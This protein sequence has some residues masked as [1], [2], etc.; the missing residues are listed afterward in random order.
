[1]TAMS[2]FVPR[3]DH[4]RRFVQERRVQLGD[5]GPDGILRLD[6]LVR[7]LQDV[8][9]EDWIDSGLS[10]EGTWVVRRTMLRIAGSGRWPSLYED[11]ALVTWCGGTGAAWAERRT[12]V[13]I[14][15][16]VL[17][18][19]V[20]LWVPVDARGRPMRIDRSFHDLYG[21]A[22][23]GRRVSGRVPAAPTPASPEV[24]AWPIRRADLDVVGH[25]NNAAIWA[26]LV[27]VSG[28]TVSR[29][30]LTHHG[31]VEDGHVVSLLSE[32]GRMWLTTDDMIRVSAEYCVASTP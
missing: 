15:G 3:P 4:G 11:V 25:V 13:E 28:A 1:M 17:L 18:E 19:T 10:R 8:A 6:G 29:A 23:D 21:E 12:D 20:A 16:V 2:E 27:E 32:P 14:D 5:A 7:F 9:T 24:A 31:P 30:S 22:S 26:A